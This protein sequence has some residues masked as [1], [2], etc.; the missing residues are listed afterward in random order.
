[1]VPGQV[2]DLHI[3]PNNFQCSLHGL[4][5]LSKAKKNTK[6]KI[7]L[8]FVFKK[9]FSSKNKPFAIPTFFYLV[10]FTLINFSTRN[11]LMWVLISFPVSLIIFLYFFAL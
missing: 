1:L 8:I 3:F 6:Q 2:P 11:T 10:F 7:C 9:K 5:L 4:Y